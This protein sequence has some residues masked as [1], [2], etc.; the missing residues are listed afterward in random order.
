[1][2]VFSDG[3]YSLNTTLD[4][5]FAENRPRYRKRTVRARRL[6]R[7]IDETKYRDRPIDLLTVDAE[8]HDLEV[9]E[10]LDFGRYAPQVIAVETHLRDLDAVAGSALYR[11]IGDKGYSLTGWCGLTLVFKKRGSPSAK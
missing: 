6:D 3:F 4:P 11:F 2:T 7:L 10:S 8:S 5:E 1:M 9:L